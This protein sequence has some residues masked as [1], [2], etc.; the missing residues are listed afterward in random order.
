MDEPVDT[1]HRAALPSG[2]TSPNPVRTPRRKANRPQ[3]PAQE[4]SDRLPNRQQQAKHA[5]KRLVEARADNRHTRHSTGGSRLSELR[6]RFT[7]LARE[8]DGPLAELDRVWCRHG[9]F[10][11]S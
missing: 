10:L 4:P 8:L 6:D 7:A 11:P 9:H 2:L 1:S 3:A 5:L